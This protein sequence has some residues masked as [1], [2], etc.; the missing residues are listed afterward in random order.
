MCTCR[1]HQIAGRAFVSWHTAAQLVPLWPPGGGLQAPHVPRT[2]K[3][4]TLVRSQQ[5]L[6]QS[7]AAQSWAH[8]LLPAPVSRMA[9]VSGNGSGD[10]VP[11]AAASAAEACC[12]ISFRAM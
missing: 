12:T 3:C 4:G 7:L 11:G 9:G 6:K 8:S 1:L 10:T 2:L 5:G